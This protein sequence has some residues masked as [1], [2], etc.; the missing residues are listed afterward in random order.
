MI[1][2]CFPWKVG[3]NEFKNSFHLKNKPPYIKNSEF[4]CRK[5]VLPYI[6]RFEKCCIYLSGSQI[7]K[8]SL[9]LPAF[10][11]AKSLLCYV[12]ILFVFK[13]AF[14]LDLFD[15]EL[16]FYTYLLCFTG[17]AYFQTKKSLIN[18][19]PW[20]IKLPRWSLLIPS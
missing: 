14:V 8:V 18:R 9:T 20:K 10:A 15:N 16:K 2:E 11:S 17:K 4:L 12:I 5:C 19:S 7:K 3:I 6:T 13:N 1:C